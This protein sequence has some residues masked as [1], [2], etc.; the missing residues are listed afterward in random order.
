MILHPDFA[1]G[2]AAGPS[3]TTASSWLPVLPSIA[4]YR[5]AVGYT[6]ISTPNA[7]IAPAP[8][9][10]ITVAAKGSINNA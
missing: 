6:V 4:I 3:F 5:A 1:K 2:A 7:T 10:T 9:T 8:T